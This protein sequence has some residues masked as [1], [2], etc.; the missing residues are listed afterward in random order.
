MARRHDCSRPNDERRI[1]RIDHF[2]IGNRI[3]FVKS[4]YVRVPADAHFIATADDVEVTNAH[5]VAQAQLFDSEHQIK[6]AD[7]HIVINY[8]FLC[9]D[10]AT[11]HSHPLADAIAEH[12]PVNG[13]QQKRREEGDQPQHN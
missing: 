13:T 11:A 12:Q 10:D 7:S 3:D 8:T 9:V 2:R 5:V 6:V 4:Y 1:D